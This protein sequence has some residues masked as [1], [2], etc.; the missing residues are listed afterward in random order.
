MDV[1]GAHRLAVGHDP[2]GN[3]V[4]RDGQTAHHRVHIGGHLEVELASGLVV[5][6]DRGGLRVGNIPGSLDNARQKGVKL[7]GRGQIARDLDQ[8]T[9]AF[10][11]FLSRFNHAAPVL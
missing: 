3:A 10:Q 6:Q 9:V 8:S 11:S 4:H 7:K 2:A 5:E 1:A